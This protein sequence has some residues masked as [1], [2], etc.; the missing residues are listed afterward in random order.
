MCK[1][2]RSSDHAPCVKPVHFWYLIQTAKMCDIAESDMLWP[3]QQSY[4]RK[5]LVPPGVTS[6]LPPHALRMQIC[7]TLMSF[8]VCGNS[9]KLRARAAVMPMNVGNSQCS[10]KKTKCW[11]QAEMLQLSGRFQQDQT[12]VHSLLDNF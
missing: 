3:I 6:V 12:A 7:V 9:E 11:L 5:G 1:S 4:S 8:L 2:Q 10:T